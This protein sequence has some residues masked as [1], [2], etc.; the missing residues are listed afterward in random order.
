MKDTIAFSTLCFLLFLFAGSPAVASN[1]V[2]NLRCEY[3]PNP[4]GIEVE[5]PR[6]SWQILAE[7]KEVTQTAYEIRLASSR[8]KLNQ[9]NRLLWSSGKKMSQQSVNVA[10]E[11]PALAS[12][13]R[14]YWQ[15]R[16]WDNQ[17]EA[18]EWS[19]PAYWEMGL[20]E[21]ESWK[22]AWISKQDEQASEESLPVQYYRTEFS[23]NKKIS[24]ARVYVTSLG[25]YNCF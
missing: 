12:M 7:E 21:T 15:V 24:S 1:S 6:L 18:T 2:S 25:L 20:L 11:G 19:E 8:A 22:A 4:I 9:K 5:S 13:Q 10:Y 23:T 14:V 16:I 17:N 3:H